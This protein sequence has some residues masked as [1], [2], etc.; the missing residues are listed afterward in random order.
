[1]CLLQPITAGYD[2]AN[3]CMTICQTSHGLT[4]LS[5]HLKHTISPGCCQ[6][7]ISLIAVAVMHTCFGLQVVYWD[8][9]EKKYAVEVSQQQEVFSGEQG[10]QRQ[11]DFK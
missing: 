4:S 3:K 1:M 8:V 6:T 11:K 7:A 9:L 10:D 5:R 2:C